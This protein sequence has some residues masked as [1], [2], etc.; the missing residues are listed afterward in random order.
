[1]K[2]EKLSAR[3]ALSWAGA[4][5]LWLGQL[6][7]LLAQD[8]AEPRAT[9]AA[10]LRDQY[11]V[12]IAGAGTG[13][14]GTAMQAARLGATVLLLEETDWL[15]GQMTAAA[16]TSMDEGPKHPECG[17]LVR[18]R[19]LYREFTDEVAAYYQKLGMS[20]ETAYW[21]SQIC[22]E[23]RVGQAILYAMLGKARAQTAALHVSLRSRVTQVLKQGQAVT[24][25][26]VEI[27]TPAGQLT[28]RI[29]SRVLVDATEWGDVIPLTGARYR[30]G[31]CTGE[32][33][34]PG[35]AIQSLT[36]T[37]VI[38]QYPG[39]VPANLRMTNAPP[40]YDQAHPQFLKSL[41]AGEKVDTRS[42]PWNFATF[43]GYRGMPDSEQPRGRGITRTHLNYNNDFP[44]RIVDVENPA[45]RLQT[46]RQAMLKTLHLLYYLQHTLGM[47][48][49]SV[50]NDEGYDS[51]YHRAQFEPWLKEK[52]ELEPWR[53]IL[54]HFSVMAY[55]RESRRIIGLHTLTAGEIERKPRSPR[56]FDNTVAL[57]DYAV[58]LHGSKTPALLELDLDLLEDIPHNTFGDRGMGPFAIPFECFVPEKLDGFLAAEKNISQSR[59]ANG[60]TRLQPSTMLMGQAAGAMAALSVRYRVQPRNLDPV[61]VQ[62]VLL[63]AGDTLQITPLKDIAKSGWEWPA[64]QLV[65]VR[66][67]MGLDEG[68]FLPAAPLSREALATLMKQLFPDTSLPN[69]LISPVPNSRRAFAQLLQPAMAAA[70]V[71]LTTAN[72]EQ[73]EAAV[74]RLEAAQAV[75]AFLE[76]RALAR[77]SGHEQTL[78][79]PALRAPTPLP[80]ADLSAAHGLAADL[81][82]LLELK[83]IDSPGYWL[84][85]AVPNSTCDGRRVALLLKNSAN[86][87]Q[88]AS[89]KTQV[90]EVC[91]AAGVLNS[92]DY[93]KKNTV[94]G[95]RCSGPYV[96][97]VISR[98]ARQLG[99]RESVQP[100]GTKGALSD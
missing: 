82:K 97:T 68:N 54:E 62:R 89:G 98:V 88:P 84:S 86:A 18:E 22:M 45:S 49:W 21:R 96:A 56:R 14:F 17:V 7:G 69:D 31:N 87:L 28:K 15:G 30:V 16:V 4:I 34:E 5:L 76:K 2:S 26:V 23:P 6:G 70:G 78:P 75:A 46:G 91:V 32:A 79:W 42:K 55:V 52:P 40:G 93:W 24:G 81:R 19:G 9:P 13:G 12:V 65:T 36:W 60:A 41:V 95:G 58:D 64:I 74:T 11:D 39:G 8:Q 3:R 10:Q 43:I 20:A 25:V 51:S 66:G 38:K 53:P 71:K 73:P 85:N 63:D 37:A 61:L 44:V 83:I 35:R 27:V 92:A 100:S 67:L 72:L 48:N 57:G 50:A 80:L 29:Q 33:V 77:L 1:M 59:L 94:A 99:F 90:L 47:T